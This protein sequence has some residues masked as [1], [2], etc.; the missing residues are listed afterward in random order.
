MT[1]DI[2]LISTVLAEILYP[3]LLSTEDFGKFSQFTE[4]TLRAI[5]SEAVRIDLERM[6]GE[7]FG[8]VPKEWKV[9]E[10]PKRTLITLLGEV[11][12]KRRVYLDEFG[13]R[14]YLLDEILGIKA[15]GRIEAN[16]FLWIVRRSADVSFEKTAKEFFDKT[17]ARVTRTTVMRCVHKEG[18]LLEQAEKSAV[19]ALSTPVVFAEFD[20]FWVNIQV[21]VKGERL[22][23]R[24]YKEQFKKTSREMKVWVAYAGTKDSKRMRPL[25][26]A[27][28]NEPEEFFKECMSVMGSGYDLGDIEYLSVASD[29]A[30]W[31]K[32][33]ALEEHVSSRA[34]VVSKLDTFHVNQKVYRAFSSEDDRSTY[35]GFLYSKNFNDFF[36]ALEKRIEDESGSEKTKAR[37]ELKDYIS[38]NIDWLDG[39][40]LSKHI[41]E[42]LITD[43]S[44]VFGDRL[45]YSYLR[46]LFYRVC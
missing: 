17:G 35:L 46:G 37:I 21:P 8:Q 11:T 32:H 33:H 23:R 9:L 26:W 18:E 25:H 39:M 40:T 44:A 20:G 4:K 28:N 41:R 27:S 45:F 3:H 6:D 22:P 34:V 10:R 14:R 42:T 7:L 15:Y 31:C 30:N 5:G 13:S 38:N 16:A 36:D 24:T 1:N 19:N 2:A 12:Y 29:G 43:L